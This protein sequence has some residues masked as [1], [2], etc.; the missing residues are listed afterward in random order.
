MQIDF[1]IQKYKK[2]ENKFELNGEDTYKVNFL[3]GEKWTHV[4][5][6]IND[7]LSS[8][9]LH[10]DIPYEPKKDIILAAIAEYNTGKLKNKT[11]KYLTLEKMKLDKNP[12]ME[13]MFKTHILSIKGEKNRDTL[14]KFNLIHNEY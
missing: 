5:I 7:H 13:R 9:F 3:Q 10:I 6:C 2:V 1:K 14:T 8:Q 11:K 12:W 4:R